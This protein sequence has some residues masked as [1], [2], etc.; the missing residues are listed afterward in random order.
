MTFIE[1]MTPRELLELASL[2]ALGLL[3]TVEEAVYTRSFHDAPATV[4]D[5]VLRRQAEIASDLQLLPADEPDPNL[6]ERVLKAVAAAV[7][8]DEATL[9]P[10]AATLLAGCIASAPL[11]AS[12]TT[13]ATLTARRLLLSLAAEWLGPSRFAGFSADAKQIVSR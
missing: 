9:A 13:A 12:F 1:P 3:D 5:E 10:L 11:T 2:D 8:R 6:R 7:E 4:Q